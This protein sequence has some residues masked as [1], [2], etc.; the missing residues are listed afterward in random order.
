[1]FPNEIVIIAACM[2]GNVMNIGIIIVC[3]ICN[4][5]Q[6]DRYHIIIYNIIYNIMIDIEI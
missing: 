5:A 4:S 6:A 2:H 3:N 1:M